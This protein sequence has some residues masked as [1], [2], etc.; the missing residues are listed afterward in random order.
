M[1]KILGKAVLFLLASFFD[2]Q[3]YITL[4][5]NSFDGRK[6][7]EVAAGEPFVLKISTDEMAQVHDIQIQGLKDVS[8]QKTGLTLITVNGK[9]TAQVTYQV[10]VDNPGS[11]TFGPAVL[12]NGAM[13]SEA[14]PLKVHAERIM[15]ASHV[16][17]RD[18][19]QKAVLL[20]LA[21]DNDS[22]FVGQKIKTHLRAY[23]LEG[24]DISID[25]V[26]SND[27][28]TIDV[29]D[30]VGPK[31]SIE[32]VGDKKYVMLEWQW[33]MYPKEPG[34]LVIPAYFVDY[35]KA[36]PMQQGLGSLAMFFGPRYERKRVYSNALSIQVLPLPDARQSVNAIG[37]FVSYRADIKPAVAKKYE[38][39]VFTLTVE[40]EGNLTRIP[41]P[42]LE[43]M[44]DTCK[45]YFSKS[46]VEPSLFGHKRSFEYIVQGLQE[47]EWKIPEQK[48]TF[49]DPESQSYKVLESSSVLFTI[50]PGQ[51]AVVLPEKSLP[52]GEHA[53]SV[54]ASSDILFSMTDDALPMKG[55]LSFSW[56]M[57]MFWLPFIVAVTIKLLSSK[58]LMQKMFPQYIKRRALVQAQKD[59]ARAYRFHDLRALHGIFVQFVRS[60]TDLVSSISIEDLV[61]SSS[62][63]EEQKKAWSAFYERIAQAAYSDNSGAKDVVKLFRESTQWLQDLERII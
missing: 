12:P 2:V 26:V 1:D 7:S 41:D 23:F 11:Y 17:G 54:S 9:K 25:Q 27:P 28:T 24:E 32:T 61:A 37:S 47:G 40:G 57:F 59:L 13:Q 51:S 58:Y 3:A 35:A 56:F 34:S 44:P 48:F 22:V 5:V 39:A 62:W 49:F 45:Y 19:S 50:V 30:K 33:E 6:I 42:I 21:V 38:G 43:G 46:F 4:E 15:K 31:K 36:L 10:Q 18:A 55:A 14:V 60:G 16:K 53:S 29:T 20:K 52:N 8:A 63:P